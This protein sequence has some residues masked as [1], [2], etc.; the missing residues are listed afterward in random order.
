MKHNS[1]YVYT[2][3]T[4]K[5]LTNIFDVADDHV[6]EYTNEDLRRVDQDGLDFLQCDFRRVEDESDETQGAQGSSSSKATCQSESIKRY[7]G[8]GPEAC[9]WLVAQ[10]AQH[11]TRK[12]EDN[13]DT[14]GIYACIRMLVYAY[15]EINF[16]APDHVLQWRWDLLHHCTFFE[17]VRRPYF[18]PISE[19]SGYDPDKDPW[20]PK[21]GRRKPTN[22]TEALEILLELVDEVQQK[23]RHEAEQLRKKED[24]EQEA[25]RLSS[26]CL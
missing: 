22:M 10:D 18:E 14:W 24:F 1:R 4:P 17:F 19:L 26:I 8:Y 2:P 25:V 16:S 12:A 20:G 23:E 6:L 7:I 5:A 21:S 3:G 9:F 11:N 13:A 15:P